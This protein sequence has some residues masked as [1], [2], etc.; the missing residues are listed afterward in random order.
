MFTF[1]FLSLLC[2]WPLIYFTF[3]EYRLGSAE[4]KIRRKSTWRVVPRKRGVETRCIDNSAREQIAN[5]EITTEKG[6]KEKKVAE[7]RSNKRTEQKKKKTEKDA[8][9][10][11]AIQIA[12]ATK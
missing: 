2:V 4:W 8:A 10:K 11:N 5:V 9:K 7:T 6:G 12:R 1:F 3:E